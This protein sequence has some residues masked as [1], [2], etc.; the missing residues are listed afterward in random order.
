MPRTSKIKAAGVGKA[1]Q[2]E[3]G[4]N[5]AARIH[6]PSSGRSNAFPRCRPRAIGSMRCDRARHLD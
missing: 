1:A 4:L 5:L 2:R 6:Q 3:A